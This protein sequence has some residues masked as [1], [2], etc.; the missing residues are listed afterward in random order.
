MIPRGFAVPQCDVARAKIYRRGVLCLMA[1]AVCVLLRRD[2]G[3]DLP[4]G[5]AG[6]RDGNGG[7]RVAGAWRLHEIC[8][9]CLT[10]LSKRVRPS[11]P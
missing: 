8:L 4:Q 1:T 10:C 5:Y 9:T 7:M 6:Q 2:S 3:A 11:S